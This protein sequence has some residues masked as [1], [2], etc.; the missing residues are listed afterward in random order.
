MASEEDITNY[1]AFLNQDDIRKYI[2]TDELISYTSS[3]REKKYKEALREYY[4][5]RKDFVDAMKIF[6]DNSNNIEYI[7][8]LIHI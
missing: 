7:L 8:S 2:P 5:T 6:A 1:L 4:T 3:A